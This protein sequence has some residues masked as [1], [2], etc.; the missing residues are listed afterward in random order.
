MAQVDQNQYLPPYRS[1]LTPNAKYDY[2]T[3]LVVEL[4]QLDLQRIESGFHLESPPPKSRKLKM[5]YKSL[6]DDV[7]RKALILSMRVQLNLQSQQQTLNAT[8][9]LWKRCKSFSQL[10]LE[11]QIHIF[12]FLEDPKVYYATLFIC[13]RFYQLAKPFLYRRVSFVSTY[14]FAQFVTILRLNP[15]LGSYIVEIDLSQIRPGNWQAESLLNEEEGNGSNLEKVLAGWRDWK[16]KT[17]PLYAVHVAPLLLLGKTISNSSTTLTPSQKKVKLSKYFKKRRRSSLPI[18]FPP[19]PEGQTTA[20]VVHQNISPSTHPAMNK[21]LLN[22][23]AFKDVPVGYINH[24]INLCPNLTCANFGS[25]SLLPDY[26]IVSK[27]AYKYQPYDLTHNYHKDLRQIVDSILAVSIQTSFNPFEKE[28]GSSYTGSMFDVASSVSSVFSLNLSKPIRKYNSLLPP[29]PNSATEMLYLS[30]ADGMIFLSDLNVKSISTSDLVL[31]PESSIFHC[32]AKRSDM[33]R[34]ITMSSMIWV[35]ARMVA[36][37][38][39]KMFGADLMRD[40]ASGRLLFHGVDYPLGEKIDGRKVQA[41]AQAL[42]VLDLSDSGMNKNL[43]WAQIIDSTTAE[44]Q[45]LVQRIVN[46][47]LVSAFEEYVIQERLRRGPIGENYFS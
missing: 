7:S 5:K 42:R 13:K 40:P 31:V 24:L 29:L 2:R 9:K 35:N 34:E 28:S 30:R 10:P 38:L 45:R 19:T 1:L 43:D 44:G 47:E 14:R 39:K 17:S 27:R 23:S 26:K 32:L 11:L 16:F 36:Q 33:M 12:S 21:F 15:S 22:Y 41:P 25:L 46:D 37:F 4:T 8:K 3:H 6:L 20:N 18:A